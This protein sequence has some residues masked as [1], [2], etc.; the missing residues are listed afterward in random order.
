MPVATIDLTEEDGLIGVQVA[1]GHVL[2][3]DLY[4]VHDKIVELSQTYK[5]KPSGEFAEA[6]LT[7]MEAVGLP[8]VSYRLAQRFVRKVFDAVESLKNADSGPA[9]GEATPGLP[10]SMEPTL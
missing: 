6:V 7:L 2:N 5:G 9:G 10:A 3:L 8:R 4:Q 1:D